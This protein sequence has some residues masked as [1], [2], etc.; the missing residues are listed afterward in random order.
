MGF[1]DDLKQLGKDVGGELSTLGSELKKIGKETVSEIK[2]DPSKYLA[3]SVKDVAEGAAK[4][5]QY[6][7]KEGLPDA[8]FKATQEMERLYRS[9]KLPPERHA[10]YRESR[11]K[12]VDQGQRQLGY[13]VGKA[14]PSEWN[15]EQLSMHI[16]QLEKACARLKWFLKLPE[17]DLDNEVLNEA[18]GV[19]TK[20][21]ERIRELERK[22]REMES[23]DDAEKKIDDLI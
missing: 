10:A 9:G 23:D 18:E 3:D 15:S 20:A 5:G 16:K 2:Q 8:G 7:L 4:F 13:L 1:W 14:I 22:Q 12:G 17:L 6:M 21:K 11:K 19:L